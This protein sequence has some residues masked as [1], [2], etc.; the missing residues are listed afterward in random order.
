[1][2]AGSINSLARWTNLGTK[3][4]C[5]LAAQAAETAVL[6]QPGTFG[7]RKSRS[8]KSRSF[9]SSRSVRSRFFTPDSLGRN[10]HSLSLPTVTAHFSI[11]RPGAARFM[12]LAPHSVAL[13]P[14]GAATYAAKTPGI[15]CDKP[16]PVP[17]EDRRFR[18]MSSN[19]KP[20]NWSFRD[21]G[22]SPQKNPIFPILWIGLE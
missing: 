13:G 11:L 17:V 19:L 15:G 16:V 7:S 14:S 20:A 6:D 2:I 1:M 18:S 8:T 5:S 21:S 22:A 9:G 12:R 3:T 4:G 10:S